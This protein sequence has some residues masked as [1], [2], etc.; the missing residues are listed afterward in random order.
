VA[1]GVGVPSQV[2]K[3]PVNVD[4]TEAVPEIEG[5]TVLVGI[6]PTVPVDRPQ[7]VVAPVVLVAVTAAETNRSVSE[8]VRT[9]VVAVAPLI[10]VQPAGTVVAVEV[11]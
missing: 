11:T 8:V 10:T 3:L 1:V 2:P 4:P 7:I 6:R 5:A 9:Y